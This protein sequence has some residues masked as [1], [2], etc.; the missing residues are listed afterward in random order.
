MSPVVSKL[1]EI[2][3]LQRLSP[4]LE[5]Q[6]FPDQLQTAY[7]KEISCMD[8]IFA[9]QEALTHHLKEGGQPY[10][11]LFDIEKAFDSIEIPILLQHLF[12]L[13]VK[14]KFWR[15]IK[16][17]YTNSSCCVRIRGQLSEPFTVNRGVKQGSI[18]SPTLFLT[19]MDSLLKEMRKERHGLSIS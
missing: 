6:G 19:V 11:C 4:L 2:I 1:L 10:L 7:Q 12:D 16:K 9:T 18:L 3:L 8:A 5:E 15:L 17:W 13:G 14:G